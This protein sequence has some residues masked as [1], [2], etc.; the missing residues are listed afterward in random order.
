[1]IRLFPHHVGISVSSMDASIAWY[2]DH[3][4][5]TVRSQTYIESEQLKIA[6]INNGEYEIELFEKAD[7]DSTPVHDQDVLHSFSVQGLKHIAFAVEDLDAT[8]AE[9]ERKEL[10]LV[11][12]PTINTDLGV[13]YC[14][15]RDPDGVLLEF[16][17]AL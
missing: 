15:I 12:P 11:T 9:L 1:M 7:S 10:D 6:Y 3:F 5:F 16:L 14:F 8:W 13:R 17:T 2:H 4:G